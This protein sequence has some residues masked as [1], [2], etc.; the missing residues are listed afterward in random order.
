MTEG[1]F[2]N[3]LVGGGGSLVYPDIHSPDFVAGTSGWSIDKNGDAEFNNLTLTGT[4]FNGLDYVI[5][6]NGVFFYNGTPAAG[7]LVSSLT[8][9]T[10]TDAK[11]NVYLYGNTTYI[12]QGVNYIAVNT[13]PNSGLSFWLATTQAGPWTQIS[14]ILATNASALNISSLGAVFI[15]PGGVTGST[16]ILAPS[17]APTWEDQFGN[18][19]YMTKQSAMVQ[20]QQN[21]GATV[22]TS[23]GI[24][25]N[26]VP[27]QYIIKAKIYALSSSVNGVT[28]TPGFIYSNPGGIVGSGTT[29]F[30][31]VTWTSQGPGTS[32]LSTQM[33]AVTALNG[34][35][36]SPPSTGV[37]RVTWSEIEGQLLI[38]PGGNG[39]LSLAVQ[40]SV[41]GDQVHVQA[42]TWFDVEKVS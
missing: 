31:Q 23:L 27:G 12:N 13:N 41:S 21:I 42:G 9:S 36:A 22:L 38:G 20:S 24:S 35:G 15:N 7:N 11:G 33:L 6:Q 32:P 10:G 25:I 34:F 28:W 40:S 26:L 1:S 3:P 37:S 39:T 18:D 29:N 16:L 17:E 19:W 30:D 4:T 5:N 14:N 8:N 2:S